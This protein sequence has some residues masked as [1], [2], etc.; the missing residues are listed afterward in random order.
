[1]TFGRWHRRLAVDQ[2]A[3][4]RRLKEHRMSL[5]MI[6]LGRRNS[7]AHLSVAVAVPAVVLAREVNIVVGV[8]GDD[9]AAV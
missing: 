5:M 2:G 4:A 7:G 8:N 9:I 1:M 6:C 3:R